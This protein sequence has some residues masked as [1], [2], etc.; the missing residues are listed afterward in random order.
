MMIK[1]T[2]YNSIFVLYFASEQWYW[3]LFKIEV[4]HIANGSS[5]SYLLSCRNINYEYF[6]IKLDYTKF[7]LNYKNQLLKY[8][9]IWT[10]STNLRIKVK[11]WNLEHL[12]YWL[13]SRNR[14]ICDPEAS[15][16]LLSVIIRTIIPF[17]WS[18]STTSARSTHV[19][20]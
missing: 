16:S 6:S 15:I 18:S 14:P 13:L 8:V 2:A 7:R 12:K 10:D 19:I 1:Q 3:G 17:D 4:L 5:V 11:P 20:M 9:K